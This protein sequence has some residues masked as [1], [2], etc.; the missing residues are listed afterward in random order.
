MPSISA[1]TCVLP[2][3]ELK[4]SF[5]YK[6]HDKNY[7]DKSNNLVGVEKRYWAKSETTLDMCVNAAK[8]LIIRYA[9]NIK[10]DDFKS[11]IDLRKEATI[12]RKKISF[13]LNIPSEEIIFKN[14]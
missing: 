7:T 11:K 12:I 14:K 9:E 6:Y 13:I 8:N 3:N 1:I 10:D 2:K 4:N 5:L